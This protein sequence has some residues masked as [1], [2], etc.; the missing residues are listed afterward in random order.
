MFV[1]SSIIKNSSDKIVPDTE[2]APKEHKS[3]CSQQDCKTLPKKIFPVLIYVFIIAISIC[4]MI[5]PIFI[6]F[7]RLKNISNGGIFGIAVRTSTRLMIT[8]SLSIGCTLPMLSDNFLDRFTDKN[9]KLTLSMWH[10]NLFLIACSIS[11]VLYLSLSDYYF[12]PYLYVVLFR[13]KIL[14]VGAITN[15]A[16]LSGT[17]IKSWKMK[18]ILFTPVPIAAFSFVLEVY[19]LLFPENSLLSNTSTVFYYLTMI[20]FS[21]AQIP[22]FYLLWCRYRVNK[23]LNNEE[24][25]EC[26]YMLGMLF[27]FIAVQLVNVIFGYPDSWLNTGDKLLVGY[28]VAQ[29]VCI[30]LATVLPTRFMRKVVQVRTLH[31]IY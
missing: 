21:G 12:M 11:G 8:E 7:K 2:S 5:V 1:L 6:H 4:A 15:Y 17:I 27:Y 13:T 23:T 9:T 19:T 3:K 30:L 31:Y 22:W 14:F 29:I 26:V 24:K 18:L 25:K 20:T 28:I 10:R 16:V